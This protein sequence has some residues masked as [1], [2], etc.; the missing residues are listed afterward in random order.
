[1]G[2]GTQRASLEAL[3]RDQRIEAVSFVGWVDDVQTEFRSAGMLLA[4]TPAEGFGLGVVEAMSAGLPV[5]ASASGGHIETIGR[6]DQAPLFPAQDVGAGANCLRSM[7]DD[8][9]R[10]ALS[11]AGRDLVAERFSLTR[12]VDRLEGEYETVRSA[13]RRAGREDDG[14]LTDLVV[15]SL[16]EWD[17]VWRRNQFIVDI[18]LR[19]NPTLRVLFVEPP[20]DPLY[21]LSQR[22]CPKWP[23]FRSL[24]NDRRLRVF[25]PVKPV[26]RRVGGSTADRLLR[27]Q[28]RLVAHHWASDQATLWINDITYAPLIHATGWPTVYD[29]TDDWLAAPFSNRELARLAHHEGIALRD[30]EEIV[31]CARALAD[32][33]GGGRRV[34]LVPNGVDV[35]H[36]RRPRPRPTDLP[37]SPVAVYI[38]TLHESRLDSELL[39]EAAHASPDVTFA[40]VGPDA[41]SP[42]TRRRL[43]SNVNVEILGARSYDAVPAYF[44]HAD[45]ILVPH[46]VNEFTDSLDPIKAYECLAVGKP[47]IATPIAGFRTLGDGVSVV[48]RERFADEVRHATRN[49]SRRTS[50]RRLATWVDRA[51]IFERVLRA[52]SRAKS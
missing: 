12:H 35:E 40:L 13:T 34:H 8:D 27:A 19:R 6:I 49:P 2:N 21:E 51:V 9:L 24:R 29:V 17:D 22:R 46:L 48:P 39:L 52:T 50:T 32:S 36:F 44:Q 30:E 41:L 7:L 31:V 37:D 43:S 38:G 5:V 42:A 10:A 14:S 1:V 25:R 26:P 23:R 16:E 45:V 11:S 47:T 33:K 28:V 18:L 15:C 3:V 20:V 4:P